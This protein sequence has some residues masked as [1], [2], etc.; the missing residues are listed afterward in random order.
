[1]QAQAAVS[2]SYVVLS[3]R[4]ACPPRPAVATGLP[5]AAQ[6]LLMRYR[7]CPLALLAEVNV[8]AACP[9]QGFCDNRPSSDYAT[10]ETITLAATC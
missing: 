6:L 2:V 7:E 3:E 1:M 8:A 9:Q 10:E 5:L 4:R